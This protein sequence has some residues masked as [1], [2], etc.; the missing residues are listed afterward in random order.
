MAKGRGY[1]EVLKE[2]QSAGYA[3]ADPT[4]DVEGWDAAAKVAIL[5]NHFFG[6]DIKPAGVSRSGISRVTLADVEAA[7]A[8]G[9]MV[10]L[11]AKAERRGGNVSAEVKPEAL[12]ATD[13]L[14]HIAGVTNALTFATDCLGDVTVVGPGA[15]RRATGYA[16]LTDLIAI[17]RGF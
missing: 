3:E 6:T 1:D 15:G 2:A 13:P 10:K 11:V 4:M 17:S 9:E 5:A 16:L 12:P 14:A 8:R 7:K